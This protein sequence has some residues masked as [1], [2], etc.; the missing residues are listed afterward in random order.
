MI[1]AVFME[2]QIKDNPV[3]CGASLQIYVRKELSNYYQEKNTVGCASSKPKRLSTSQIDLSRK[4]RFFRLQAK[5]LDQ[6]SHYLKEKLLNSRSRPL[7]NSFNQTV[8]RP[9]KRLFK[10]IQ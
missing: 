8:S 4:S 1:F 3:R 2:Y 7:E 10:L 6:L 9:D 5:E